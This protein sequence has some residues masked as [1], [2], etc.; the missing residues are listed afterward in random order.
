MH[1][2]QVPSV[3]RVEGG[4]LQKFLHD[5]SDPV[6]EVLATLALAPGMH[7]AALM[8]FAT[9]RRAVVDWAQLPIVMVPDARRDSQSAE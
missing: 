3:E 7:V 2:E 6:P 4:N 9:A 5:K 8:H 1:V